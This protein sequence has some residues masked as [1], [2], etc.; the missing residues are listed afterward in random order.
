MLRITGWSACFR[1]CGAPH[2]RKNWLFAGSETGA[3]RACVLYSILASCRLHGVDPFAYLTDV[4]VRV[5]RHPARDALGL[6]PKA[7]K[8][9]LQQRDAAQLAAGGS[10][11]TVVSP[12]LHSAFVSRSPRGWG[13]PG[14][15]KGQNRG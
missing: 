1:L 8:Q 14:A 6:A 11:L 7:W 12:Q 13:S 9:Q 5:H 15:Y 2:R 4:L 10:G 3:E